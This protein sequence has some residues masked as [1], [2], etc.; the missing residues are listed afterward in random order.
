[1]SGGE[2]VNV[3]RLREWLALWRESLHEAKRDRSH[4]IEREEIALRA[5][6]DV[7]A[8]IAAAEAAE[9]QRVVTEDDGGVE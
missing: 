3:N 7:Q 6:R 8:Q 9:E 5:I 2:H 1:M 4:A